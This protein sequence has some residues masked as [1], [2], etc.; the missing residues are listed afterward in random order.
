MKREEKKTVEIVKK[1]DVKKPAV[2]VKKS[3]QDL[4]SHKI[5]RVDQDLGSYQDF[6]G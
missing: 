3:Y 1:P 2:T 6:L 4:G 5:T